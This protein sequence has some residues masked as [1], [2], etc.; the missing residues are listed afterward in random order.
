MKYLKKKKLNP[1]FVVVEKCG[2]F[3]KKKNQNNV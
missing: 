2:N 1:Y 3:K